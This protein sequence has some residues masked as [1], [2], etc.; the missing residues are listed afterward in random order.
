VNTNL[1]VE[2]LLCNVRDIR[3]PEDAGVV[4]DAVETTEVFESGANGAFRSRPRTHIRVIGN[5]LCIAIVED[6]NEFIGNGFVAT[7]AT[8]GPP[9]VVDYQLGPFGRQLQSITTTEPTTCASHEY[10]FAV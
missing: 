1:S 10:D 9:N 8:D 7:L 5:R 3:W 6:F 4:Y 2:V